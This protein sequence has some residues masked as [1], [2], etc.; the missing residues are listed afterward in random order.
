MTRTIH[1]TVPTIP[2]A[3][4]RQ[5]HRVVS[6][7]GRT[8]ASNYTPKNDPVNAYKAA[9]QLAAREAYSGPPL[10]GP[11]ALL[12]I[13]VFPRPKAMRWKTKPMPRVPHCGKPDADNLIKSL[14]DALNG[15]TIVD[16]SRF[17]SVVAAKWIAEGDE[18]PHCVVTISE[19]GA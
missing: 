13:F 7:G 17:A 6:S 9:V 4:P 12:A 2:V 18:Q 14:T 5:R 19:L 8:F 1:F 15:L 3:Q 16:D 10:D 11:L